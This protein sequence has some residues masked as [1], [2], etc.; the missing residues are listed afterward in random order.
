MYQAISDLDYFALLTRD[1]KKIPLFEAAL[2][3]AKD[4]YPALDL[5]DGL[6]RFDALAKKLADRCRD[7]STEQARLRQTSQFF[8]KDCGFT[9]NQNNY[10]DPDNSFLHKVMETRRGIPISLAVLYCELARSV[11]L[12]A[13]GIGFP[14][15]F[16]VKVKL[17]EGVVVLDPFTGQSLSRDDLQ[18]RAGPLNGNLA[19]KLDI[20]LQPAGAL[21]ILTRMLN[22]L[23]AIYDQQNRTDLLVK[24]EQRLR[25]LQAKR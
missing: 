16:L 13:D 25:L 1:P 5:Q 7:V 8:F 17:H 22:N 24:V 9:G 23:R 15:H 21:P 18:E 20:L 19:S 10:Y 6:S 11:G 4:Q 2:S 3:I 14:G 12:N